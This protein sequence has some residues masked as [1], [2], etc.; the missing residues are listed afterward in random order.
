MALSTIEPFGRALADFLRTL[1]PAG[2]EGR[3]VPTACAY[4][5]IPAR[6]RQRREPFQVLSEPWVMMDGKS[7]AA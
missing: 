3:R 6:A 4:A 7:A 2:T 5:A 1:T